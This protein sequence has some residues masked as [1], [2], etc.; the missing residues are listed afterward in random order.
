[1]NM[2]I[3]D[4]RLKAGLTQKELAAQVGVNNTV[5]SCW[6]S[7]RHFPRPKNL[8]SIANALN[9]S[10]DELLSE[11]RED[12]SRLEEILNNTN[13]EFDICRDIDNTIHSLCACVQRL[14]ANCSFVSNDETLAKTTM[15]LAELVKARQL[16]NVEVHE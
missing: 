5:I 10:V 4:F 6:E 9:C 14:T 8:S 2:R 15:T 13:E 3:K 12:Q 11:E 7:G 16:R 1:M